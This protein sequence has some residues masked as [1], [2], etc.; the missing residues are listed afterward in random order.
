MGEKGE[1]PRA[2]KPD[3]T[4]VS[5]VRKNKGIEGKKNSNIFL[6]LNAMSLWQQKNFQKHEWE[7]VIMLSTL[8]LHTLNVRQMRSIT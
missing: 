7:V 5:E 4:K 2:C 3:G 8:F 6:N 1:D